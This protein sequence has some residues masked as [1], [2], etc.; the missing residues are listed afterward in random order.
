MSSKSSR[1][2]LTSINLQVRD[3]NR[4]TSY[5][6]VLGADLIYTESES[7]AQTGENLFILLRIAFI[8]NPT[9]WKDIDLVYIN[10]AFNC[11]PAV[12]YENPL[13]VIPQKQTD[14]HRHHKVVLVLNKTTNKTNLTC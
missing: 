2:N 8:Y 1:E 4:S 10:V 3:Q 11:D 14:G 12:K 9:E 13:S 7:V 5:R 6:S